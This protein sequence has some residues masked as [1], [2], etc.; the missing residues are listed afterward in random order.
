MFV[1]IAA[2]LALIA[3]VTVLLRENRRLRRQVAQL[4]ARSEELADR[5][6]ERAD[7]HEYASAMEEEKR[8]REAAEAASRAKSRFLA[9]VSHEIRTPLNGILG[10]TDLILD[11]ALTPEQRTYAKAVKSSGE[12]LLALVEDIL[13]FS[14]I[15]AGKLELEARP[16]AL[17]PL[18]EGVV[19][20]LSPRAQEKGLEIASDIDERLPVRVIG[21]ATRLRQVLLNLAGNAIKFTE[22]GGLAVIVK[23]A[24]AEN[25]VVFLVRDT[26]IGI[27]PEAHAR[28]FEE[29]EQVD[30]GANRAFGGAGLGLAIARRLVEAMGGRM[31]VESEPGKGA[32]FHVALP[33]PPA[34]DCH[35]RSGGVRTPF[36]P[37][38]AEKV[39]SG[40]PVLIV[41]PAV[42]EAPLI[43]D[44]LARWGASPCLVTE[45]AIAR[46]HLAE[47]QWHAVIVDARLGMKTAEDLVRNAGAIRRRIVLLAPSERHELTRLRQAGFTGYLIKPVRRTSLAALLEP[48]LDGHLAAEE[49]APEQQSTAAAGALSVLLAEDN[50]VNALLVQALLTKLGHRPTV[51]K[52]GAAAVEV[53]LA[54]RAAG[55]PFDL[56]LMD[57]QM[58]RLDGIEATR[59]I[60]A[61]EAG[62]GHTPVVGL[63]ANGLAE[64]RNAGLAAGMDGFLLKPLDRERLAAVLA[65]VRPA[66]AA[67]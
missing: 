7:R 18:V 50:E 33:L 49:E 5:D 39:A 40:H 15:E 54:A 11:T 12:T 25:E 65:T 62:T 64:D 53:F 28:I 47:R 66:T 51:A 52:D 43:A 36:V 59:R 38:E 6:F 32:C 42:V 57:L 23:P 41:S 29:F 13:D 34:A 60:R 26:G 48:E 63:S 2:G 14:K 31:G 20:L 21:D 67:A 37:L 61:A 30:S 46:R 45:A 24:A 9:I 27:H 56:V 10:M 16:F 58:P 44:Q 19:E 55:R 1:E 3:G 4:C 17:V 35:P 22:R 8:A